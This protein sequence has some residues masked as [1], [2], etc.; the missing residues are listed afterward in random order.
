[1]SQ[2]T[3][4]EAPTSHGQHITITTPSG[5]THYADVRKAGA[6]EVQTISIAG[7]GDLA[8]LPSVAAGLSGSRLITGILWHAMFDTG[9]MCD[10]CGA[11]CWPEHLARCYVTDLALRWV[12]TDGSVDA[13]WPLIEHLADELLGGAA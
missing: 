8:Q 11:R 13:L 9:E 4:I 2:A 6:I 7:L 3:R 1:V 10:I 5:L 12:A